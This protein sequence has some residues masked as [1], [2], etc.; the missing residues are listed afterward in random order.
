MQHWYISA[1]QHLLVSMSA[2]CAP[3]IICY[4]GYD[5]KFPPYPL[6]RHVIF[7]L[8]TAKCAK[9]RPRGHSSEVT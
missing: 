6:V 7:G 9:S 4:D 5:A 1:R 3:V 2:C 8:H